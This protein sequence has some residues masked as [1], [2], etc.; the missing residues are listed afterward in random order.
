ML[1]AGTSPANSSQGAVAVI[2]GQA[3]QLANLAGSGALQVMS[4]DGGSACLQGSAGHRY[5]LDLEGARLTSIGSAACPPSTAIKAAADSS[6]QFAANTV[7]LSSNQAASTVPPPV[8]PSYYEYYAYLGE[9]GSGATTGCPLYSQGRATVAPSGPG[10]V[11]LDLGAPCSTVSSPIEYGTQLYEGSACTPDSSL[12]QMVQEW[13]NGYESDHGAGTA[14]ITLAVGTSNSENGIDPGLGLPAS[15]QQSADDWHQLVTAPY[16]LT[17]GAPI[18]TWGGSDL[19]EASSGWWGSANSVTWVQDYSQA[20][21]FGA[22]ASCALTTPGFLA[23]YGDDIVGGSGEDDGWSAANVYAVAQGIPAACA[24]PEIYYDSMAAEWSA[25]NHAYTSASGTPGI[26]FTGVMVEAVS[27][28]LSASA[29]WDVLEGQ[30]DQSP[31]IPALTQIAPYGDFQVQGNGPQ[32]TGISPAFG[33]ATGGTEVTVSGANF[34]GTEQVYFG[35]VAASSFSVNSSS[36]LTAISPAGAQ[37]TVN[38]EVVTASGSSSAVSGDRFLYTGPPCTAVAAGGSPSTVT[39]GNE[40]AVSASATCPAGSTPE[41]SY[42]TRAGSSG[43]WTLK[44]AWIGPSWNWPTTGLAGTYQVLVWASDGPY[45]VPQ[46]QQ[47]AT[48]TVLAPVATVAGCTQV[49][50]STPASASA[51]SSIPVGANASCPAGSKP[52]YAYFTRAGTSGRWI[53]RAAWIGASWSWSTLGLAPGSYQVLVWASDGPHT[54]PQVQADATVTLSKPA[55]CSSLAVTASPAAP[56][57]GDL[58]TVRAAAVCPSGSSPKYAYF[59]GA[60]ASGPWVLKDAWVGDTWTLATG[61]LHAGTYYVLVWVSDGPFT[62]PQVQSAASIKIGSVSACT[63]L[64]VST[65]AS[66]V[67]VGATVAVHTTPTCPPGASPEY[68]FFTSNSATGPWTL[69]DA[70]T[71]PTWSWSTVGLVPGTYYVLAWVSDGPYTRPQ[72][73][74]VA[75]VTVG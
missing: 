46:A 18:V 45:T 71:G 7:E 14:A 63:G 36:S 62:V 75:S 61:S 42:F 48:V 11:V 29:A 69:R 27:G 64:S 25:L 74:K 8:T 26:R 51:G 3:E 55:A 44:A 58:V 72:V 2:N 5:A 40:I 30:S 13:M 9:C 57:S 21:G 37:G 34:A 60:S 70:W 52:A 68:S 33:A 54:V 20:A 31:A 66:T 17:G 6:A 67:A 12:Q 10:I 49:S 38:L 56:V 1:V 43:G 41:Y 15:L 39:A 22:A 59:L 50:I 35:Q 47:A 24:L 16:R 4:V 65:G 73:E 53:L 28:T 23:D 19:E 32:V